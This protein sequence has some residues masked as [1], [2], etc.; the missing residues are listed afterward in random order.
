MQYATC[1]RDEKMARRGPGGRVGFPGGG[2]TLT[3]CAP[4]VFRPLGKTLN[5]GCRVPAR[6]AVSYF[7]RTR[8]R[9]RAHVRYIRT[10]RAC[11]VYVICILYYI[12]IILLVLRYG[13]AARQLL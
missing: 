1:E 4:A 11:A 5:R 3:A 13:M 9:T 10:S 7:R 2:T 12:M 8:M 6:R